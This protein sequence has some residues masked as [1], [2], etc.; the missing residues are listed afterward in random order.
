MLFSAGK[1]PSDVAHHCAYATT[2]FFIVSYYFTVSDISRRD[3]KCWRGGGAKE[4][5]RHC[6]DSMENNTGGRG[7]PS[8]I[9]TRST[10]GSSH[11]ISGYLPKGR[12]G[13]PAK[14]YTLPHILGSIIHN[15]QAKERA[16]R[17]MIGWNIIP[18]QGR[19]DSCRLWQRGWPG[20][21]QAEWS[22][23]HRERH[24]EWPHLHVQTEKAQLVN[25]ESNGGSRGGGRG[26][27]RRC[28]KAETFSEQHRGPRD[29]THS[30]AKVDNSAAL[31]SPSR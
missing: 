12:E 24:S 21:R 18:P 26:W 5:L 6:A 22:K 31:Q 29:L 11:S 27:A 20:A 17:Q 1:H 14:R 30:T 8:K 7:T 2:S 9:K 3:H 16:R 4:A 23:S 13:K 19:R 25:T 15:R 28:L 10:T